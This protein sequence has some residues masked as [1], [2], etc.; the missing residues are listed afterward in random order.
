MTAL[1]TATNTPQ[2]PGTVLFHEDE[3]KYIT[4]WKKWSADHQ[5]KVAAL[6]EQFLAPL[7]LKAVN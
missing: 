3:D 1:Y 4:T 6:R 5:D 2:Y 7:P